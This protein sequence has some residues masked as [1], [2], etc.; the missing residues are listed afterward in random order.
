M[1]KKKRSHFDIDEALDSIDLTFSKYTPSE[2]AFEFFNLVRIFF[3]EDFE[4]PNPKFH[5]FIVDMLYGNVKA[6]DF[7]YSDII[8]NT[9][10]VNPS[11][12][13]ILSTRGSAKSTITTLFYP[14][15]AAIKGMT[16]VTG[17]LSHM[18]ILSDSQQGGA[19]DQALL[20]GNAFKRSKF[21]AK[22]FEKI[23]STETEVELVRNG[24]ESIEK[25][26]MLIKFKGAQALSLDSRVYRDWETDR[27]STRL[28]SSHSGESRMPSSA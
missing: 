28:N 27:K 19:R 2:E 15:V 9:I 20:M 17:P 18:L 11:R 26:H 5:Y 13:G 16:P 25:R 3:G 8:C 21:A 10:T 12:I 1:S 14:I 4:V 7:P 6:K 22:W 23:R 24:S